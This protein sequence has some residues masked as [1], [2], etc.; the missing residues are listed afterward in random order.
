M[1][2]LRNNKEYFFFI[3]FY[4]SGIILYLLS[5]KFHFF[6]VHHGPFYYYIAESLLNNQGFLPSVKLFPSGLDIVT[7]QV[8]VSI[9]IYI[10]KLISSNYWY[11][12]FYLFH[13]IFWF[14]ALQEI[15]NFSHKNSILEINYLLLT[16]IIYIQPY[17]LNQ[18][19]AFSNEA[20]YY[21]LLIYFIF[22][23]FG[24]F[25]NLN[26]Y[27]KNKFKFIFLVL[28]LTIGTIFR[29]H[30]IILFGTFLFSLLFFTNKKLYKQL[31]FF[32]FLKCLFLFC[33]YYFADIRGPIFFIKKIF[34]L[35]I[36][37][38]NP[39][40]YHNQNIK[41][42]EII[43]N[44]NINTSKYFSIERVNIFLSTFSSPL[45]LIKIFKNQNILLLIN[46]IFLLL[47]IYSVLKLKI[48][49]QFK[50]IISIYYLFS[51]IFIF[52]LPMNEGSYYLPVSFLNIFI[53]YCLFKNIFKKYFE[54][55]TISS[56]VVSVSFFYFIYSGKINILDL[57]VYNHKKVL[58]DM[59]LLRKIVDDKK[60]DVFV[61]TSNINMPELWVWILE[62]KI[63]NNKINKC[64]K[65][66]KKKFS[67]KEINVLYLN[68]HRS[69]VSYLSDQEKKY[70]EQ[71]NFDLNIELSKEKQIKMTDEL[72][73]FF[74]NKKISQEN[75]KVLEVLDENQYPY[76]AY[77]IIKISK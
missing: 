6:A 63:C 75:F 33:F 3:I 15:K 26:F 31:I 35:F 76:F 60:V 53:F 77:K 29:L 42:D 70:L 65:K 45:P 48:F 18:T 32:I 9:V 13:G 49:N 22:Y 43:F 59:K 44:A 66:S 55:L 14:F 12:V 62:K 50:Y 40:E 52:F 1:F 68:Q 24:N 56:L 7:P 38:N 8:G 25:E 74:I 54:I 46:F 11:L 57:E 2:S 36:I 67:N 51:S 27:S 28:F 69:S 5:T 39:A 58:N 17:N 64:I 37:E 19:A 71:I 16:F 20:I 30:N 41:L 10:S 73:S 34:S 21:P 23:F 61:P 47:F 4:L 72:L